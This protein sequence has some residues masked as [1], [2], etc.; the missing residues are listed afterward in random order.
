MPEKTPPATGDDVLNMRDDGYTMAEIAELTGLHE[1]TVYR[2]VA[3][4]SG[5]ES[6]PLVTVPDAQE[7]EPRWCHGCHAMVTTWPCIAC[8][9]RRWVQ[10][11][12]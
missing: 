10:T 7:C 6:L 2:I 11:R 4:A 5:T 1:R 9:T 8:R 3:E 12:P